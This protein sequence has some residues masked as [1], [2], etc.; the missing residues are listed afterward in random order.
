MIAH[1]SLLYS[2]CPYCRYPGR[3][4][5]LLTYL[6]C[7]CSETGPAADLKP[8]VLVDKIELLNSYPNSSSERMV[9][10]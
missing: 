1:S 8:A 9:I 7:V 3:Q 4:S 10:R 2:L 6:L 5:S